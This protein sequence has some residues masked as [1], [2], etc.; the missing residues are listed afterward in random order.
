MLQPKSLQAFQSTLQ[1]MGTFTIPE[2]K[3]VPQR[4]VLAEEIARPPTIRTNLYATPQPHPDEM[5]PP[6]IEGGLFTAS[7]SP[8]PDQMLWIEGGLLA[9]P[10]AHEM[11]LHTIQDGYPAASQHLQPEETLL[12]AETFL[13]EETLLPA[14][15]PFPEEMPLQDETYPIVPQVS[16]GVVASIMIPGAEDAPLPTHTISPPTIA[17]M[18]SPS[19][20]YPRLSKP[21]VIPGACN[22]NPK[23]VHGLPFIR[24]YAACLADYDISQDC[25]LSFIDELN[26]LRAGIRSIERAGRLV[27]AVSAVDFSGMTRVIGHSVRLGGQLSQWASVHAFLAKANKSTFNPKNLKV[28]VLNSK[29][30]RKFL[31]L[32]PNAPLIAPLRDNWTVP[33]KENLLQGHRAA[34]QVPHRQILAILDR[35]SDIYLCPDAPDV[36]AEDMMRKHLAHGVKNRL[37]T[38]EIHFEISRA[39]AL[40][41]RRLAN[42]AVTEKERQRLNNAAFKA[43]KEVFATE[44]IDWLVVQNLYPASFFLSE[45]AVKNIAY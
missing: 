19:R 40:Q 20:D 4:N 9:T 10:Q 15:I 6:P 44:K 8:Q 42:T 5:L 32:A 14:E 24:A 35:V 29:S 7:Q 38:T 43:D 31:E 1:A 37:N 33:A 25:F 11:L 16:S 27:G 21:L 22:P 28:D 39:D 26:T 12:P 36:E 45:V 18:L 17:A 41:K 30:L 3:P 13:P 23:P 34:L 2:P